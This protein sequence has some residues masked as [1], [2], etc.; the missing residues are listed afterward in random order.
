MPATAERTRIAEV[1]L[2]LFIEESYQHHVKGMEEILR[3]KK[4]GN[5]NIQVP[6]TPNE[7]D[8]I[9][10]VS[11]GVFHPQLAHKF[12]E[13]TDIMQRG[14]A[15]AAH[16]ALTRGDLT[17]AIV[18]IPWGKTSFRKVVFEPIL[19]RKEYVVLRMGLCEA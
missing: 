8:S 9:P 2:S 3:S 13:L 5:Y 11:I 6:A 17:Q 16:R 7:A 14:I 19:I 15:R 4:R 12:L 1:P 10:S 18:E